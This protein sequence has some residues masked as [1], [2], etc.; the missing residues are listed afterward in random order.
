LLPHTSSKL[1][2]QN[3]DLNPPSALNCYDGKRRRPLFV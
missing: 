1:H 2:Q 3:N